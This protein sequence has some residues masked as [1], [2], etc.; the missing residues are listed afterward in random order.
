MRMVKFSE[1][2]SHMEGLTRPDDDYVPFD[3]EKCNK[4]FHNFFLFLLKMMS[5]FLMEL[6]VYQGTGLISLTIPVR[7]HF[8][9]LDHSHVEVE[10]IR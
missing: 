8:R 7:E 4:H 1:K 3:P 6:Q 5:D 2:F 10:R 9:E